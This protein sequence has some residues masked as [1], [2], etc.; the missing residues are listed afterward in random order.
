MDPR[1]TAEYLRLRSHELA[2][3]AE[4][5]HAP[6][7]TAAPRRSRSASLRRRVQAVLARSRRRRP[8]P[9]LPLT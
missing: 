9:A 5:R 1:L 7:W 4:R 8:A 2:A 3:A 6:S